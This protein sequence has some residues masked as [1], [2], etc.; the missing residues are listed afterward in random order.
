MGDFPVGGL[1]EVVPDQ[2]VP[3]KC[4]EFVVHTGKVL[5]SVVTVF[6]HDSKISYTSTG[7]AQSTLQ[8]IK[9]PDCAGGF[10]YDVRSEVTRNRFLEWR[11]S[12]DVLELTETS[13]DLHLTANR[14]K[15]K[16]QDT[17]LLSGGVAVYETIHHVVILVATVG[18]VHK[19]VFPHPER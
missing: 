19:M 14:V 10:V 9:V 6:Q 4:R 11:T 5:A 13:L 16:F 17:P 12:H 18:S 8:D 2:T 3:E 1:R 7:G 15:Y